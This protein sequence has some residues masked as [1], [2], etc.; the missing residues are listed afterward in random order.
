MQKIPLT[1]LALT[2]LTVAAI[3]QPPAMRLDVDLQSLGRTDC[4][5]HGSP[6]DMGHMNT[7]ALNMPWEKYADSGKSDSIALFYLKFT[8]MTADEGAS[9]NP[10]WN[11]TP[12][13][14]ARYVGANDTA[15]ML[16]LFVPASAEG[17]FDTIEISHA[18][19]GSYRFPAMYLEPHGVYSVSVTKSPVDTATCIAAD[20]VSPAATDSIATVNSDIDGIFE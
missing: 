16:M 10:T 18:E 1:A 12:V 7:I 19:L 17:R 2:A 3:A 5:Y 4:D 8:G 11:G 6:I 15:A 20:S 14:Y 9:L 13:R